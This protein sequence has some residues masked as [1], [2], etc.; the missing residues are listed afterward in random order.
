MRHA[1]WLALLLLGEAQAKESPVDFV[2]YIGA[3]ERIA[4]C[5]VQRVLADGRVAVTVEEELKAEGAPR[6][7]TI[8]GETGVGPSRFF[9]RTA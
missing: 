2:A 8:G 3:A 1:R 4:V 5:R 9:G 7:V 6:D